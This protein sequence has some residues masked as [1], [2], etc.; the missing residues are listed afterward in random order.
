[1]E[2]AG[3]II[4]VGLLVFLAHFF[5]FLFERT[6]V[7]DVLYLILIGLAIGPVLGIVQPEDF[8]KVGSIFTTIA[9]VVI[10]F[11]GGL[12]LSI[13]TLRSTL[14]RTV[15]MT[16]LSYFVTMILLSSAV[17]LLTGLSVLTSVFIGAVLAAPAPTVM[18]PLA[19]LLNLKE[20]T[21]T[22]LTLESSLGEALGIVVS[23][24]VLELIRLSDI[25]VG[26]V[27]GTIVSTFVFAIVVGGLGGYLWSIL[28]HRM[29][30]L[31]HAI[32]TTP[33]FVFIV[34]GIA[35]FLGFSGPVA[36]LTCGI[37]LGN[38]E[39]IKLP[40]FLRVTELKPLKHNETE[41]L[42][43]GEIVFLIKTF[44]F[45][46][47]GLTFRFTNP[48]SLAAAIAFT[49]VLLL[50]RLIATQN[51]LDRAQTPAFDASMLAVM[52]PKGT[53]AAVLASIPLQL[54]LAGGEQVQSV[55]YGVTVVS[56]VLTSLLI[57][58]IEKTSVGKFYGFLLPMYRREDLTKPS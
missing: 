47:L 17:F 45:V 8:G 46:F 7:P 31:R 19:R 30:Q 42:F 41:K 36:A 5:V 6:K 25:Q 57:P 50:A 56:I 24:T 3:V 34:Y 22:I 52:V 28:M 20:H 40:R 26:K 16:T 2:H 9:L 49:V 39:I 13:H 12:E 27:I 43:F 10:L 1:M 14:R 15:L 44:F 51:S 4:F 48:L 23:L 58:L 33:A 11:E 29:R 18:I 37:T 21:R 38:S 35:E 55:V 54:G 32:F 53:A